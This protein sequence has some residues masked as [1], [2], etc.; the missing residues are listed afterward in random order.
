M[1]RKRGL[2]SSEKCSLGSEP[3]QNE[4]PGKRDIPLGQVGAALGLDSAALAFGVAEGLGVA[5]EAE[6]D[7]EIAVTVGVGPAPRA[8]QPTTH[9][10]ASQHA[11]A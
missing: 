4:P 10:A 5:A 8:L 9:E 2:S 7:A 6:A 11:Q 1:V 3:I